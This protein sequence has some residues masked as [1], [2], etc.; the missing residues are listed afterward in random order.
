MI[1]FSIKIINKCSTIDHKSTNLLTASQDYSIKWWKMK[2]IDKPVKNKFLSPRQHTEVGTFTH[3]SPVESI[4][5]CPTNDKFISGSFDGTM[6]LWELTETATKFRPENNDDDEPAAKKA[7]KE[8]ARV[9]SLI[10]VFF[11]QLT[12]FFE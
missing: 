10:F 1:F 3:E 9:S 5:V 4:S 6:L 2:N 8:P 12:R 7:K 11:K